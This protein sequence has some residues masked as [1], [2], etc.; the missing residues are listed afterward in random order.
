[1]TPLF[2]AAFELQT[3]MGRQNW[4][5]CIIGGVALLRWG[6][7]RLTRDVD[8]SL[9]TGFGAEDRFI[10]PLL[11]AGY[12]PRIPDAAA[13]ARKNRVLLIE[14][15]AGVPID[16]GLAALPYEYLVVD[17]STLYEFEP[18][19]ELRTC[20]AED[21]MVLKLFASRPR[22]II[23]VE[24]VA[25]RMRESL[26]WDYVAAQLGPLA[27][28]KEDPTIMARLEALRHGNARGDSHTI[29]Q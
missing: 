4:S 13:F 14:S 27:E 24:S 12:K 7:P 6:K 28:L 15:S 21:L 2:A 18:G 8:V 26:D 29:A 9:L 25:D 19:C 22:D 1:M 16:L 23:D 5:F 17:R 10:E 20:S 11:A 3:F